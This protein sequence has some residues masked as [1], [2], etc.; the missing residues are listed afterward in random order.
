MLVRGRL[1][2]IDFGIAS[3]IQGDMTSVC[4]DSFCGTLNYMSPEA[5]SYIRYPSGTTGYKVSIFLFSMD[6]LSSVAAKER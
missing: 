5:T 3:S 4:K 1:K 2:L 6:V